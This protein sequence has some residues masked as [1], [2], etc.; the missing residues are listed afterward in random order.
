MVVISMLLQ[1]DVLSCEGHLQRVF[2]IFAYLKHHKH[3]TIVLDEMMPDLDDRRAP[4]PRS[5]SI[6]GSTILML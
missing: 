2:H 1:Y 4:I 3:P 6:G 5:K